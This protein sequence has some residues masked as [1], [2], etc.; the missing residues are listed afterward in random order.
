MMAGCEDAIGG[1]PFEGVVSVRNDVHRVAVRSQ[2]APD[3]L[4]DRG[5]VLDEKNAQGLPP[6]GGCGFGAQ[7]H[8]TSLLADEPES[9]VRHIR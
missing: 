3:G 1:R 9:Q 6:V 8:D 5:L 7:I 2:A 4:G